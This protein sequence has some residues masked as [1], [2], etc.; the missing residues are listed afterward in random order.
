MSAL[1]RTW[2][3]PFKQTYV[4]SVKGSIGEHFRAAIDGLISRVIGFIVRSFLLLTGVVCSLLV[5]VSGLLFMV[6][7]ACTPLLPAI[8]L[9]LLAM[10]VGA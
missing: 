4:G 3:A 2:F 8:S 10:G 9:V 5:F 1:L 6:A 7:W